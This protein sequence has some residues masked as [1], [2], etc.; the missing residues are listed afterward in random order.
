MEH[1]F[2]RRRACTVALRLFAAFSLCITGT[3]SQA[4]EPA[5]RSVAFWYADNPPLQE[6]AQFEWAVVESGHVSTAD[7]ARIRQLGSQPFAY[8]SVGEFDGDRGSLTELGLDKGASAKRNKAW[9][10][11]VMDLTSPQWRNHLFERAHQLQAQG[12]AGLFL[13]TLDSFQLLPPSQWPG[14]QT[15]L[16]SFLREL[17][18]REPKLK[19]FFNRGFEV[20][21]E[22]DGVAAAVAVESIHAGWDAGAKRYR[23]V[24][25]ADREWLET[26][27]KPL[28]DK[29]MPLVAIDYL[30]P[31]QREQA[32]K[33]ARQLRD[34]GFI[35][36]VTTPEL[37]YLGVST[38]EVQPR[39]I[40]MLYDPREGDLTVNAG[41]VMLGG[42]L[43][44][45][46]YRIDYFPVDK[47][48]PAH[49]FKGVY[50]GVV[51]WMNTGPPQDAQHFNAW[52]T[53]RLDEDVPLVFL[54]GMP[55]ENAVLLKRLGLHQSVQSA[56][57]SLTLLSQDAS[58]IGG[59]EAPLRLRTREL[60]PLSILPGGPKPGL[61]LADDKG[62]EFAPVAIGE[63]GGMVMAP[64]LVESNGEAS[65]WI[66]DPF[67][68]IQRALRLP[69]QPHPDTTTENGRRIATVHIDG[70]GFPSRAE[71][72]GT[73]YAGQ[74]VLDLFIKPH[75]FLTSVSIIEGEISPRGM[76]PF[77]AKELEPI[78]RT[79]FADPKVEVATHTFSH[80][81]FMQPEKAM[82][83]DGFHPEYGLNMKIPGYD[84][85]DFRREVFG[86]RDY[87]NNNLTTA[88]KP[89]KMIFWPGDALPD[90]AT[91]QYAYEAGLQNVNGGTTI[92]TH[93]NPS[94]TGLSPLLRPTAGGLQIYAPIINENMYTN[95]WKGPFYGFRDVI[96]TF[97]LT[98]A[99]RRLRGLHL[100]YHFYSGTKQASIK[101]MDDIYAFMIKQQPISL[102]MSDYL[103]RVRGLYESSLARTADGDW[104]ILGMN[105]LRTVRIDPQMG[106]PDMTRSQGVA[107]VRDLSQGRYV[108]LSRDRALLALRPDRDPRP[109]LEEANVPLS[110]WRYEDDGRITFAFAGEFDIQF[111]V[112]A[113]GPCHVEIKGQRYSPRAE[114]GLWFFT[115]PM[116]QV[117]DAQLL[118]Q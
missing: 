13:D 84:K 90:E 103:P 31:S 88:Q 78:A 70:D 67:A 39:R 11:Q 49:R 98:D 33:L 115:L 1:K 53:Q 100:Y 19:L 108:H 44:Y 64:Y 23:P 16:A 101:V 97:E 87:I 79:I 116:K 34:E 26:H 76:F 50:A 40:A 111:S 9:N 12:Y 48:L 36:F 55:I 2:R 99:P 59:F 10:S 56:P 17:H 22:L 85:I 20:L 51:S 65:R 28:R 42:L 93:A 18:A 14:Q 118:C 86:S 7:V 104:Q 95:L 38:L 58:L 105:A 27:L 54:A 46:G 77:L 3:A 71:I 74:S 110:A 94:L 63:W 62:N 60:T 80:P 106:W 89:V 92:I 69:L 25:Q 117:S 30:P 32:R 72:R 91:L 96:D 57:T 68:F 109:A 35:P 73:P 8:L 45:L 81:F 37:D 21:P 43:E 5:P 47:P 112:R 4:A 61:L 6:L 15:A 41:H 29:G 114:N 83:E 102:W 107:G 24:S 66:I 75:P 113:A 82:K 52:I